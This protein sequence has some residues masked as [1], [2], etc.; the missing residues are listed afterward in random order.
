MSIVR[1]LSSFRPELVEGSPKY[2]M[3]IT[4]HSMCQPGLPTPQGESN[5][6]PRLLASADSLFQSAKS[7]GFSLSYSSTST[8][9]PALTPLTLAQVPELPL[10]I[11]LLLKYLTFQ[12]L[13]KM[14][15]CSFLSA[16]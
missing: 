13:Q 15:Q 7:E 8:R 4:E 1:K 6:S 2:F 14:H 3:L 9:A 11:R 5:A 12:G 16:H 10:G